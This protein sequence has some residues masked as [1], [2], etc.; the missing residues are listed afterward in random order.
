MCHEDWDDGHTEKVLIYDTHRS[1]SL[2]AAYEKLKEISNKLSEMQNGVDG[3]KN[4]V[5][6]DML[7]KIRTEKLK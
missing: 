5:Y 3:F 2:K 4:F 1:E 6:Y 7:E